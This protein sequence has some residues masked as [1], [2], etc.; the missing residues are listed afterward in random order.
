MPKEC[1]RVGCQKSVFRPGAKRLFYCWVPKEC[2]KVGCQKS[3][4]LLLG[5]KRVFC[6]WVPKECFIVGCQKSVQHRMQKELGAKSL[7]GNKNSGGKS[8]DVKNVVAEGSIRFLQLLNRI[9]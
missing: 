2:L 3:V 9:F 8:S 1:L 4:L 5:A 6:C 7:G